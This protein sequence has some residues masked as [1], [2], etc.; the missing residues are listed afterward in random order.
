MMLFQF[1]VLMTS[2]NLNRNAWFYAN[3]DKNCIKGC[4]NHTE[5]LSLVFVKV[6]RVMT[7]SITYDII[8]KTLIKLLFS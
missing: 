2:S 3:F 8:L 7:S 5:Q 4:S 6:F 1:K